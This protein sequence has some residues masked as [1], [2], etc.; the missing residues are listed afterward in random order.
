MN[1]TIRIIVLVLA[2]VAGAISSAAAMSAYARDD[3]VLSIVMV[4]ITAMCATVA[5]VAARPLFQ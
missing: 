4:L 3:F 2:A 1:K 5:V